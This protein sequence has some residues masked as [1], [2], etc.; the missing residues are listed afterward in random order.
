MTTSV[1][2]ILQWVQ[3][4]VEQKLLELC[5]LCTE[6]SVTVF[7]TSLGFASTAS[8]VAQC[9]KYGKL[10]HFSVK[11]FTNMESNNFELG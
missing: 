3:P 5:D 10:G 4:N 8:L 1:Q 7:S 6:S 2:R 11:D 9:G